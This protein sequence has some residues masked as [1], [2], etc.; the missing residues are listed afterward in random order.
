MFE[1]VLPDQCPPVDALDEELGPVWR[2]VRAVPPSRDDFL[3]HAALGRQNRGFDPCSFASCSMWQTEEQIKAQQK[4]PKLKAM[5]PVKLNIPA[6][7]GKWRLRR[8]GHID[9]WQ[10]SGFDILACIEP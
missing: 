5:T 1:E 10:Y 6:K 2:L 4:L 8:T 9:F 7:A 3:S